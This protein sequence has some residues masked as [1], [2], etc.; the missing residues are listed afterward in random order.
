MVTEG[1]VDW[2]KAGVAGN[3]VMAAR[4]KP[5]RVGMDMGV[6]SSRA[7]ERTTRRFPSG[8]VWFS[9]MR[10]FLPK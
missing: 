5:T 3:R 6:S 8:S 4:R 9:K 10:L 7:S 1:G 2:E